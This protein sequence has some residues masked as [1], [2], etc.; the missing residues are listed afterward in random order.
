MKGEFVAGRAELVNMN[1]GK[2]KA[3]VIKYFYCVT[4]VRLVLVKFRDRLPPLNM[5]NN[6]FLK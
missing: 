1:L 5:L 4:R 2:G 6:L 3:V